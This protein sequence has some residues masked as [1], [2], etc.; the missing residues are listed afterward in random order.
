[1]T[2]QTIPENVAQ[3]VRDIMLDRAKPEPISTTNPLGG[4]QMTAAHMIAV[5]DGSRLHDVTSDVRTAL[6]FFAPA[7]RHGTANLASLSAL[8]DWTNRFKGP[9]SVFFA[10][11]GDIAQGRAPRLTAIANYHAP[12]A[13]AE[14]GDWQTGA[15]HCDHRAAYD[16]PL[17]REWKQWMGVS[18]KPL[19][20]DVFGEFIE[21]NA[22]SIQEPTPAILQGKTDDRNAPWENRLIDIAQQIDGRY[23]QLR[24]LLD[25]S[26]RFQVFEKSDLQIST[27]RDTG[28]AQVQFINEHKGA[29]GQPLKLP[30]LIIIAIP[31]FRNGDLFR[32]PV[33]FRYRKSGSDVKFILSP[34]SPEKAIDLA[35]AEAMEHVARATELPIIMGRPEA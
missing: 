22:L 23:G 5:P 11:D 6:Q 29:D 21:A 13:P 26:R 17:S 12:G 30:N 7:R 27:N 32:L 8:I 9:E 19:E 31:V 28:E 2:D 1:M 35:F 18:D 10:D 25:L 20:K 14:F 4:N 24:Q 34:Y 3:T 16:F 33:R 15:A